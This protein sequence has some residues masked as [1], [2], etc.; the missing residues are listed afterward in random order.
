MAYSYFLF[1]GLG[2]QYSIAGKKFS[3]TRVC[4]CPPHTPGQPLS[5][6][7]KEL[8]QLVS[9]ASF[10]IL[11]VYKS[12]VIFSTFPFEIYFEAITCQHMWSYGPIITL[13]LAVPSSILTV[14]SL[15][16]SNSGWPALG[17]IQPLQNPDLSFYPQGAKAHKVEGLMG[18]HEPRS[19]T[20]S[21]FLLRRMQIHQRKIRKH[22]KTC[23]A[24]IKGIIL[25]DP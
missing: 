1:L 15:E 18:G 19:H 13:L 12:C 10:K 20:V 7:L 22:R 8:L 24:N 11:C 25:A 23:E 5:P 4:R 3:T 17:W 14:I 16:S 6:N 21:S 9:C 2:R